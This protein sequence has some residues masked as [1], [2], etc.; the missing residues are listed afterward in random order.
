MGAPIHEFALAS[1]EALVGAYRAGSVSPAEVLDAVLEQ[2]A[3]LDPSLRA[4]EELDAAGARVAARASE[5]RWRDGAGRGPLDGI[6]L[7]VKDA[8]LV[9]GLA[10]R[11]G[12]RRHAAALPG[13]V[14]AP[15]C[16]RARAGGAVI[17]GTTSAPEYGW[18]GVTDSPLYGACR[19]PWDLTRTPGGS[20]GGSAVAVAV[21][22][23]TLALGTDAA[24]SIRIPAAFTGVVGLK[25]TFGRV[26][27]YPPSPQRSLSHVG[28]LARTVRDAAVLL[29]A[30]A[31]P[32]L[33]DAYAPPPLAQGFADELGAGVRGLRIGVS[34]D[35]GL[36]VDV[37]GE[38]ADALARAIDALADA[39][40]EVEEVEL[41]LPHDPRAVIDTL[42][43][44]NLAALVHDVSADERALMDPGL[45]EA[46]RRGAAVTTVGYVRALDHRLAI[47]RAVNA[48]LADV[49]ALLT[50]TVPTIA[51][52][53]DRNTPT[54]PAG[55]DLDWT[56]CTLTFNLSRHPAVSLPFG[57]SSD[58]LPLAL[59]IVG[60]HFDEAGILRVAAALE[61][62]APAPIPPLATGDHVAAVPS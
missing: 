34:R 42:W 6:P 17:V 38:V 40:A 57:M 53:L 37:D 10:T 16:A 30:I 62:L 55:T 4:I 59:Q 22:M 9:D 21:G 58:G 12:G 49:D 23:A 11:F 8:L 51:F 7:V 44:A 54:D 19:N 5:R 50:P 27:A 35:L 36:A 28:P 39:G 61:R 15:A 26:P 2:V 45:V 48:A 18:K 31:R 41:A 33:R 3:A 25:P 29:D 24:G 43:T 46:A 14:D 60:R 47:T 20:S 13:T 32:D 56:P 52:G 1:A